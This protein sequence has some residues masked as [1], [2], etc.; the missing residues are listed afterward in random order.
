QCPR[1]RISVPRTS[2]QT[3]RPR[4]PAFRLAGHAV[5]SPSPTR[6]RPGPFAGTDWTVRF[7]GSNDDPSRHDTDA[8]IE[9]LVQPCA[10]R[11]GNFAQM[12]AKTGRLHKA[13]KSRAILARRPAHRL[14]TG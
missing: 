11:E 1:W 6:R 10:G 9:P 5:S 4:S 13:P 12:K 7:A 2:C 8:Q 3:L 14:P